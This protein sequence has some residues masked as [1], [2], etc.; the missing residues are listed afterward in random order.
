MRNNC[1]HLSTNDPIEIHVYNEFI[2]IKSINT[3]IKQYVD[4]S[5]GWCELKNMDDWKPYDFVKY[6]CKLY[7]DKY[8]Q[9]YKVNGSIVRVYNRISVFKEVNHIANREYR[10]F[11]DLSFNR[12]FNEMVIPSIGNMCNADFYNKVMGKK[13]KQSSN[14]DWKSL[15][16]MLKRENEKFEKYV[17]D[18]NEFESLNASIACENIDIEKELSSDSY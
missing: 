5:G 18:E 12:H 8:R 3:R 1:L 7:V 14:M 6:F 10:E 15:D 4:K 17:G 13:V 11:Y 9:E 2:R 16:I